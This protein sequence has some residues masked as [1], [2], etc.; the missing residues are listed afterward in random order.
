MLM[1]NSIG[2]AVGE[3]VDTTSARVLVG[4]DVYARISLVGPMAAAGAEELWAHEGTNRDDMKRRIK[5]LCMTFTL[6]VK[7]TE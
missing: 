5:A 1:G 3:I 6:S 7:K 2:V 4:L